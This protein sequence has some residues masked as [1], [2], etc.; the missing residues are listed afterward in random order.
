[1]KIGSDIKKKNL[2]KGEE[3]ENQN[4]EKAACL[5]L[6]QRKFV[7]IKDYAKIYTSLQI[8]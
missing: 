2:G 7:Q 4:H 5:V 3:E 6:P 8:P 1:M